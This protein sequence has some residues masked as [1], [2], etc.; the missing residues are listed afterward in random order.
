MPLSNWHWLTVA[1]GTFESDTDGT[2][3]CDIPGT[4]QS[5]VDGTFDS[6]T[7]GTFQSDMGGTFG[8]L[9]SAEESLVEGLQW[10]ILIREHIP[11]GCL[12][13]EDSQIVVAVDQ[14]ARKSREENAYLEVG[15]IGIALDDTPL[16]AVAI[17][18]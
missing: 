3:H 12:A 15:H 9:L 5:V 17:E 18:E 1:G 6:A 4:F 2:F 14:R 11:G 8:P 7:A 13:L 16:V 10:R